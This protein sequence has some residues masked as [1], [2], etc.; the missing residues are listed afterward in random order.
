MHITLEVNANLFFQ[1]F[2]FFFFCKFFEITNE[3]MWKEFHLLQTCKTDISRSIIFFCRNE[4][5]IDS[6]IK[7]K[8]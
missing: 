5:K 6:G 8:N 4:T 1:M 3:R 7:L 2:F